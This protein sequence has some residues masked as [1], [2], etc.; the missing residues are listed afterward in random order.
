MLKF[1]R[2]LELSVVRAE[3]LR[4]AFFMIEKRDELHEA[5][6]DIPYNNLVFLQ[7]VIEEILTNKE[8]ENVQ[9]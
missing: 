5:M 3:N 9:N 1:T 8:L 7:E 6:K 4:I 2:E